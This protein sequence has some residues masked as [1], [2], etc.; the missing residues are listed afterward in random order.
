MTTSDSE[1]GTNEELKSAE[2][3]LAK[4]KTMEQ[5]LQLAAE[6]NFLFTNG[7]FDERRLLCETV[8]KRLYLKEG[9]ITKV[10]LNSPL[11]LIA[12]RAKGSKSV[13]HGGRYWI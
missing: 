7:D 12:S 6:L 2:A 4:L 10:E 9:T 3:R 1:T 8:L 13:I 5:N 11:A